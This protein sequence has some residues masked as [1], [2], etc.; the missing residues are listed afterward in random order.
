MKKAMTTGL[1]FIMVIF[2][3]ML[4]GCSSGEDSGVA[5]IKNATSFNYLLQE[6]LY[7]LKKDRRGK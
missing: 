7:Q 1:A 4:A 3:L 2:T 5:D 6:I